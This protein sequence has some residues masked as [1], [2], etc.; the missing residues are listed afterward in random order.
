MVHPPIG[1]RVQ[2][3]ILLARAWRNHGSYG[4]N[5][6]RR[7][8]IYD[9]CVVATAT[10]FVH[11]RSLRWYRHQLQRKGGREPHACVQQRMRKLGHADVQLRHM[12][13]VQREPMF[14]AAT[15]STADLYPVDLLQPRQAVRLV[16]RRVREY[17]ELRRLRLHGCMRL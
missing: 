10:T 1:S 7:L 9:I 5:V 3:E 13:F 4:R 6:V 16:G 12:E 14:T 17:A 2:H 15:S 11:F 8:D